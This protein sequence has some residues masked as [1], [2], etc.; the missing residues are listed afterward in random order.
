MLNKF[1]KD[2]WYYL[3]NTFSYNS[4]RTGERSEVRDYD[5]ISVTELL[6]LIWDNSFEMVKSIYP[7]KLKKACLYWTEVHSNLEKYHI[8]WIIPSD[9]I[10]VHFKRSII[11]NDI[12]ILEAEQT[13]ST[14][15]KIGLPLTA[16]IDVIWMIWDYKFII[17]YK[18][19]KSVRNVKSSKYK[20]QIALYCILSW[21][22][23]WAI[24]YL[25]RKNY[26]LY[27]IYDIEYYIKVAYELIEYATEVYNNWGA[28][29]LYINNTTYDK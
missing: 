3:N 18:T 1:I 9:P 28:V 22:N 11:D 14:P 13:F 4:Y 6:W 16:T 10:Y 26:S 5:S 17:D 25:N 2:N 23:Y 24:L 20:I 21:I 15:L 29:N 7:D 19:S 27:K 12:T 8:T